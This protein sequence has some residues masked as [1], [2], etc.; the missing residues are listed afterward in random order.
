MVLFNRKIKIS[1]GVETKSVELSPNITAE[2][3]EDGEL[4]GIEISNA[5]HLLI[6]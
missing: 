4:I 3:D 2:I 6:Y 5:T 1:D